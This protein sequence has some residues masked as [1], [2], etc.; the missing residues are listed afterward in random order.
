MIEDFLSQV[1]EYITELQESEFV[2][3]NVEDEDDTD[4]EKMDLF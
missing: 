4:D 1:D 3:A 2:S